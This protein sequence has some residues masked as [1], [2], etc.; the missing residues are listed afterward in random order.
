[1]NTSQRE[2][3]LYRILANRRAA[4]ESMDADTLLSHCILD[5]HVGSPIP[6]TKDALVT[7]LMEM[8]D[9]EAR[10]TLGLSFDQ[11]VSEDCT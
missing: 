10:H 9:R 11:A 7:F 5:K 4:Y 2:A 6:P 3:L 8:A 1:M